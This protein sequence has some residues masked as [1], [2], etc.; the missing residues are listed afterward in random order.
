MPGRFGRT[1]SSAFCVL[2]LVDST[3]TLEMRPRS[4]WRRL[5]DGGDRLVMRADEA[6][7]FRA[8]GHGGFT[9]A[10][11]SGICIRGSECCQKVAMSVTSIRGPSLWKALRS[12]RR[13]SSTL[14][15]C[16]LERDQVKRDQVNGTG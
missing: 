10:K 5:A 14:V 11:T 2:E 9:A 3:L 16:R 13:S 1:R 7:T 4:L 6:L 15:L 12:W 8:G